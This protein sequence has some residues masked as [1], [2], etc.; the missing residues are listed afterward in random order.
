MRTAASTSAWRTAGA[1]PL[2]TPR[3]FRVLAAVDQVKERR[4]RSHSPRE[5]DEF[6]I[7]IVESGIV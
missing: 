2:T 1:G 5:Y 6:A 3:S 7:G 4:K